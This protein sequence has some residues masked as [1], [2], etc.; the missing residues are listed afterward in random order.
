MEIT[1]RVYKVEGKGNL[2]ANAT[3]TLDGMFAVNGITVVEGKNGLF[4]SMPQRS[5]EK[6][7]QKQYKDIFF[8]VSADARKEIQDAVLAAYEEA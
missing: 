5:Y 1:A 6:D 3:V 2:K 8:P 7:G 4:I